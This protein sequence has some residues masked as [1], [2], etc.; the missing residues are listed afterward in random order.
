MPLMRIESD[1]TWKIQNLTAIGICLKRILHLLQ[2]HHMHIYPV[3][4]VMFQQF[5]PDVWMNQHRSSQLSNMVRVLMNPP[6]LKG[7]LVDHFF[8]N[9]SRI[10]YPPVNTRKIKKLWNISILQKLNQLLK[11][12]R[13]VSHS[14]A[15]WTFMAGWSVPGAM[16]IRC[17]WATLISSWSLYVVWV[18]TMS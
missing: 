9:G 8:G 16:G 3:D 2:G 13:R 4:K 18:I 6:A 12:A 17:D 1:R 7:S 15:T 5:Y 11:W 14:R 10:L